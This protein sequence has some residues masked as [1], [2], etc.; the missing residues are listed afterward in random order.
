[1]VPAL[2]AG[3]DD[4]AIQVG[5]HQTHVVPVVRKGPRGRGAHKPRA[6]DSDVCH[7]VLL[8]IKA[9]SYQEQTAAQSL[10]RYPSHLCEPVSKTLCIPGVVWQPLPL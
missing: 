9:I 1:M 6:Y 10:L 3:S 4:I 8:G 5:S 7:D 2:F